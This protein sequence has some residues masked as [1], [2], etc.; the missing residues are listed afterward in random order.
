MPTKVDPAILKALNLDSTNTTISKHGSSGFA[1]TFKLVG[2]PPDGG[3]G[4][5][6]CFFVKTGGEGSEGMFAGMFGFPL[7]G[8]WWEVR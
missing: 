5:E 6:K 2:K 8:W 4:R 3:D 1:G 7:L